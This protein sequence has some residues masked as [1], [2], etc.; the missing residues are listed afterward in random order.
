M[1][2]NCC[3]ILP[4]HMLDHIS[5]KGDPKL[6]EIAIGT[7]FATTALRKQRS[8]LSAGVHRPVAPGQLRRT[9]YDAEQR[10]DVPGRLVRSEGGRKTADEA[11]SEAYDYSGDTY[12][13][14]QEILRRNSVDG[15]GLR[16]DSTVHYREDPGE[17]FLNA[18]WNGEQMI[19]GDGD[20][21][22]FGLFTKS[23]DVVAHELTH[24]VTQYEAGLEYHQQSGALNESMSDVFG[25]IVKQWKL[26]QRVSQ[27]DWL[28]GKELLLIKDAALRSMKAPGT[29][30]DDPQIGKD[31]Q[32]DR[33]SKYQALPDTRRG[34]WGGVH[35]N[36]G[37]PNRAFYLACVN[38]GADYSWEKAGRVWYAALT[39]RLTANAT[40]LDAAKAT[41]SAASEIFDASAANAVRAA[42]EEVEVA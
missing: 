41:I 11:A 33:M 40:F 21:T 15:N 9:I 8:I 14:Y 10:N 42:W 5:T 6:R 22:V 2:A 38:L 30:Y 7:L 18:F 34:D 31:P 35:I 26:G 16:L 19:Y 13:F 4:P 1:N 27:A 20:G 17:P 25:S 12:V 39:T 23:L 3:S 24:G 32:P 29:A 28:I 36:S 37:I